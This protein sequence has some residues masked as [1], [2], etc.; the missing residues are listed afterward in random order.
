MFTAL[1]PQA[2]PGAKEG[3]ATHM[4]R[5]RLHF[6]HR[7]EDVATVSRRSGTLMQQAELVRTVET[8]QWD[9]YIER[10]GGACYNHVISAAH[11]SGWRVERGTGGVFEGFPRLENRLLADYTRAADGL[12][13]T[14]RVGD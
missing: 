1:I 7:K 12:G 6:E 14:V 8:E 11:E 13:V 9:G 2:G 3:R 5:C 10:L 4:L